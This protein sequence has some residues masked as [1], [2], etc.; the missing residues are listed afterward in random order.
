M[1]CQ[2]N[3]T[4]T[5]IYATHHLT[6]HSNTTQTHIPV[7]VFSDNRKCPAI[8]CLELKYG[9]QSRFCLFVFFVLFSL[10]GLE[11]TFVC[12]STVFDRS[13]AEHACETQAGFPVGYPDRFLDAPCVA[14]PS[15]KS[16][17]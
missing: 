17:S 15:P 4:Q 6:Y 8:F 1:T 2:T 16:L 7:T 13:P 10:A 11:T 5:H 9:N 3:T 12:L 14:I